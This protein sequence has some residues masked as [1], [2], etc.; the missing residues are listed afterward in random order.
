M[1]F[2]HK[3]SPEVSLHGR[4]SHSSNTQTKPLLVFLHYWGGS[5]STWHKLTSP[6]SPTSLASSYPILA[7][8]LRGWGKSTGPSAEDGSSYSI[9]AMAS[10]TA[11]L[12]EHLSND[13]KEN[14]LLAHGFV[15]V[16]HSMGAKVALGTV[17]SLPAHL[18]QQL[19]GLVLVA[20]APPGPLELPAEMKEQQKAAYAS[21]E[22][23]RWTVENVL[24]SPG[25]LDDEDTR[26][27]VQDSLSG[28]QL[29][30][31]AWP[32]YGMRED[33]SGRVREALASMGSADLRVRII[34]GDLDV[35]EPKE[36]V[37][38]EVRGFLEECG[39][40]VVLKIAAGVKHL[41]PLE[42]PEIVYQE[43]SVF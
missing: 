17:A 8:D 29:A 28:N 26:L 14:H 32:T 42:C 23:I 40:P 31:E 25:N 36:R 35:V 39:I 18:R 1:D 2:F 41:V 11:S 4:I 21:E 19:R 38:A 30:K 34:V 37:D 6:T 27:V 22:S 5:S 20:P 33:I 16:G 7:V 3:T 12:L 13:Q 43:V 10:D 24:A 15:L 9:F